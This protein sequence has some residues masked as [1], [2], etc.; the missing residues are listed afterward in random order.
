MRIA[1][2]ILLIFVAHSLFAANGTQSQL[3]T[4][5]VLIGLVVVVLVVLFLN[6]IHRKK[7]PED[8]EQLKALR[9]R[10]DESTQLLNQLQG[11]NEQLQDE[12]SRL[13]S[14]M[15]SR[16]RQISELEKKLADYEANEAQNRQNTERKITE[17]DNARKALEE[18]RQ[19]VLED[20][21]RAREEEEKN[22]TRIWA[23][24]EDNAKT[25]MRE[26]CQ[27][28]EISLPTFD[29]TNLP[30][31]F[32]PKFKPDFMVQLLGQ[33]VIFDPK[34]SQS[35]SLQTYI[36]TQVQATAKKIRSSDSFSDIYKT[37]FFIIPSIGLQELR[38][39]HYVEQG[40]SF[41]IIALE[42]FEPIVRTLKR[43]EDYD[44]ADKYD[45]QERENIVNVLAT[46]D[47]HIRQQNATNILTTIRGLKV[48]SEKSTIPEDVVQAIE[49]RRAQLRI[50]QL[51][52]AQLKKLIENPEQQ[53]KEILALIAP[54]QP[55]I[56]T[57]DLSNV[58]PI[59]QE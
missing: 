15:E 23:L 1:I 57:Q 43:L 37:V 55:E 42:A 4:Q 50:E 51:S 29:N 41:F 13:E 9:F 16:S 53:A 52:P 48:M 24:H 45:P 10:Y 31:G 35:Q 38:E 26:T 14:Q 36:K 21:K 11:K 46:Y 32:D 6:I 20:E 33:Y 49:S 54:K 34:S 2:Y 59:F 47:Q 8:T 12:N 44:L 17:L 5:Y 56:E 27:K 58:G 3:T 18:E 25:L 19:R 40:L 30:D 28:S 7:K 39:T 22:R